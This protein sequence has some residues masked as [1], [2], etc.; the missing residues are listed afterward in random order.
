M[1]YQPKECLMAMPVKD[2][3]LLYFRQKHFDGMP[4]P[5][6]ARF[7]EYAERDDFRGDMK[8]W[9]RDLLESDG[10]T[11]KPLPDAKKELDAD[12]W[13]SL[14]KSL[15]N[16]FIAMS[17]NKESFKDNDDATKFL[18]EYFGDPKTK[19]FSLPEIDTRII[20]P[21]NLFITTIIKD[22]DG[23]RRFDD[24]FDYD[25]DEYKSFVK[26]LDK[27]KY[28]EDLNVR[29]KLNRIVSS[30]AGSLESGEIPESLATKLSSAGLTV[31]VLNNIINGL[32]KEANVDPANLKR[33]KD[34]YQIILNTLHDKPKIYDVFKQYDNGKISTQLDEAI[35][36]TDYTG[37]INE[38]DLVYEKR[39][40]VKNLRQKYES[41]KKDTYKN[42]FRK[43]MTAHHDRIF[44]NQRKHN[45][46]AFS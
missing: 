40:D 2:Y 7:D 38:K 14:F 30:I 27:G 13:E 4:D 10:V 6:R 29:K 9:K 24:I 15:Q 41:W 22:T 23:F 34:E 21:L 32:N 39:P 42:Y 8:T 35:K 37:K 28:K 11:N 43:Y 1:V 26:A 46:C 36:K 16:A 20:A 18:E 25:I 17:A 19:I 31:D 5:V 3:L 33:F 45:R 44:F 12:G